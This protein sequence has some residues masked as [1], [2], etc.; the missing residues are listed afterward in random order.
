MFF[1]FYLSILYMRKTDMTAAV[2]LFLAIIKVKTIIGEKNKPLACEL[3]VEFP[4][5]VSYVTTQ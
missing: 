4:S 3:P 5:Q 1:R 2:L